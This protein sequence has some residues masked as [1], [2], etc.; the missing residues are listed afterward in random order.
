MV[1]AEVVV[2]GVTLVVVLIIL[3][4]VGIAYYRTRIR[5]LL[6]LWLLAAL[7]GVNMVVTLAE[8]FLEEGVPRIELLSSLFALGIAL[9]LLITVVRRFRWEPE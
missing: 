1:E 8:E 2:S 4:L 9:L 6:V 7:L 5:R 3:V